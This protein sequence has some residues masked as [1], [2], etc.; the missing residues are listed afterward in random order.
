MLFGETAKEKE[1]YGTDREELNSKNTLAEKYGWFLVIYNMAKDN[2]L[3]VDKI[4]KRPVNEC[5]NWLSLN[6]E[7]NKEQER[8]NK[9]RGQ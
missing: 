5:L 2:I 7:V 1:L 6:S 4:I 8:L 9:Y 3:N